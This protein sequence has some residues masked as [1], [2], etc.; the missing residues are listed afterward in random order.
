MRKLT[1]VAVAA[2]LIALLAFPAFSLAAGVKKYQ[3]TGVVTALTDEVVTVQKTDG[4]KWELT[5][6]PKAV[7]KG[8]LKVG[9]KVTLMYTMTVTGGE[10]KATTKPTR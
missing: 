3:V 6:D 2:L 7:V 5:R 1:H 4:E 8:E 9:A 10:V